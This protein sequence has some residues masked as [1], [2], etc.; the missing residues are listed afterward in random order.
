MKN[1]SM[2]I[3]LCSALAMSTAA[4]ARDT[5]LML[6]IA[7]GMTQPDAE[8]KLGSD[9]KFYFGNQSHPAVEKSLGVFPTNKKT[10]GVG[11]TDEF[12]CNWAFLSALITLRDRALAEGGNAVINIQSY[13]KKNEVSSA[14]EFECHAGGVMAGV[15]LKGEI[16]KLK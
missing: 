10:N 9:V 12:A 13:Y 8:S 14:T 15:A 11:K 1:I 5:K 3:A 16:V 7:G 2:A 4:V 6:P